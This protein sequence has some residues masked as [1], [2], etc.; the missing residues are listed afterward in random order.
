MCYS[1]LRE[2]TLKSLHSAWFHLFDFPTSENRKNRP[3]VSR[4]GGLTVRGVRIWEK[5]LH[6]DWAGGCKMECLPTFTELHT[7]RDFYSM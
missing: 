1:K 2:A 3:A 5:Y 7:K 6:H 4:E